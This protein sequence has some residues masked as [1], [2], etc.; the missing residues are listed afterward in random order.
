MKQNIKAHDFEFVNWLLVRQ[1]CAHS[2][3][4]KAVI[5]YIIQSHDHPSAGMIYQDL[6]VQF[7]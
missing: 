5:D 3:T 6:E 1:G 7:S 2:E 4:R